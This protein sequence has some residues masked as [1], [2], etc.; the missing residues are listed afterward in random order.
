MKKHKH[1]VKCYVNI[2]SHNIHSNAIG[3]RL[4]FRPYVC[5]LVIFNHTEI[6]IHLMCGAVC[7]CVCAHVQQYDIKQYILEAI[8]KSK[9]YV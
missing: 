6:I 7:V 2:Y 4:Q 9:M 8:E 5:F 3:I 1:D